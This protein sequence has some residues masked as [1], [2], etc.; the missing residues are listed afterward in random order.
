MLRLE[1]AERS[2]GLH[3]RLTDGNAIRALELA[4]SSGEE[5]G[6]D[7][8]RAHATATV[9]ED[10]TPVEAALGAL[11]EQGSD[12]LSALPL[13]RAAVMPALFERLGA[14]PIAWCCLDDAG[15]PPAR[16]E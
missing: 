2:A 16:L 4:W 6:A 7:E 12:A 1:L 14:E 10:F 13:R 11:Q 9:A 5:A 8:F 3:A 15:M